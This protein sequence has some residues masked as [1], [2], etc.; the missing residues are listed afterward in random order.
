MIWT[1]LTVEW[2]REAE[3][4]LRGLGSKDQTQIIAAVELFAS[5]GQG[6]IKK[7]HDGSYRLRVRGRR[8]FLEISWSEKKLSVLAVIL[9]GDAF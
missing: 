5:S 9:R 8:V 7:L 6:D 1:A 2:K 3:K 4:N